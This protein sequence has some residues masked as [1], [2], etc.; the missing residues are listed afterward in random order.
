[1]IEINKDK[2]TPIPTGTFV[3]KAVKKLPIVVHACEMHELFRV[4]TLEGVME[5]KAGDFLMLGVNGEYYP[6]A[7]DIFLKTYEFCATEKDN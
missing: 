7:R 1:M 2:E 3:F 4:H 6:C 5:G